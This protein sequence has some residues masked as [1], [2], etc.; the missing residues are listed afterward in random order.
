MKND[1][2]ASSESSE[3]SECFSVSLISKEQI[4]VFLNVF[5]EFIIVLKIVVRLKR[6]KFKIHGSVMA[7]V[8]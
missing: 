4:S 2:N 7:L 5:E 8:W 1:E 6:G 3:S